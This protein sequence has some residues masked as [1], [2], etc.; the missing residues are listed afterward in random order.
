[1]NGFRQQSLQQTARR[2]HHFAN[3]GLQV[4]KERWNRAEGVVLAHGQEF[5][6]S[7]VQHILDRIVVIG[8][9]ARQPGTL[10]YVEIIAR[11]GSQITHGSRSQKEFDGLS[12]F[13]NQ[14]MHPYSIEKAF[15]AGD[16]TPPFLT[17]I[18]LTARDAV[19]VADGNWVTVQDV[20]GTLIEHL[21]VF[22]QRQKQGQKQV[23][24]A[25]QTTVIAASTQHMRHVAILTQKL[26]AHSKVPS[27]IQHCDNCGRHHFCILQ[28]ALPILNVM[29]GLQQIITQA[30]Y[31]YNL[32]VHA[33]LRYCFGLSTFTLPEFA[34][35]FS[36]SPL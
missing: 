19:V 26:A 27:E 8:L 11:Q 30:K 1:M 17:L 13:G 6:P 25:M 10:G 28:L 34:W 22:A 35:T 2:F 33:L 21:P 7:L 15:F 3:G 23:G 9:V 16:V 18:E 32:G 12:A 31:E 14:D 4:D 29:Q 5:H 24:D 20:A 36:S